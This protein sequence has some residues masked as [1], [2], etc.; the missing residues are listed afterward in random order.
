MAIIGWSGQGG[1]QVLVYLSE[2]MKDVKIK[3]RVKDLV[4][5]TIKQSETKHYRLYVRGTERFAIAK[6][7]VT[8]RHE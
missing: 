5:G 8:L 4:W 3:R 7:G 2:S 1:K 6:A